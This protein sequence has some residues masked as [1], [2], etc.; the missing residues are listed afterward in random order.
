MAHLGPTSHAAVVQRSGALMMTGSD[1][2]R[3]A[4]S[5]EA[6]ASLHA[7]VAR[8]KEA[9]MMTGGAHCAETEEK[10]SLAEA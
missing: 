2:R 3:E 6:S 5:T 10:W 7:A 1:G 9:A 4:A 8:M